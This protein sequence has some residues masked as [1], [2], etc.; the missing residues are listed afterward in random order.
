MVFLNL[1]LH[2]KLRLI[3]DS[4]HTL[5]IGFDY[6]TLSTLAPNSNSFFSRATERLN[7]LTSKEIL[8]SR[9]RFLTRPW[10]KRE[11]QLKRDGCVE[12]TK[13]FS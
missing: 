7:M 11:K 6:N 1:F 3:S 13:T 5:I 8:V 9:T 2:L 10:Q 12:K 4:K